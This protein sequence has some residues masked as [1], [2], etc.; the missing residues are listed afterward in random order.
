MLMGWKQIAAMACMAL[1]VSSMAAVVEVAGVRFEEALTVG[2]A[3][4]DWMLKDALLG[5]AL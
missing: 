4:V 1:S 3:P 5:K 2:K